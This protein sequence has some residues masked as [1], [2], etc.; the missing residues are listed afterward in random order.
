MA[1][2]ISGGTGEVSQPNSVQEVILEA[3]RLEESTLFSAK[4]HFA[5][6]ETWSKLHLWVGVPNSVAAAIAGAMA[7]SFASNMWMPII[8]GGLSIL[9]AGLAAVQTF[10]NP[11]EKSAAHFNAGNNYDALNGKVRIFWTVECWEAHPDR[12]LTE[13]LKDFAGEKES[14]NRTCPQIP[15]WAYRRAKE[16]IVK[17]EGTYSVDK[18]AAGSMPTHTPSVT[19]DYWREA[20]QRLDR[21][22][23]ELTATWMLYDDGH[24]EW[25]V[26]ASND[27]AGRR[28]D[29]FLSEARMLGRAVSGLP[30]ALRFPSVSFSDDADNWLNV[31]A[32]IVKPS[33]MKGSGRNER[34][35]YES[36]GIDDLVDASKVACARLAS[37]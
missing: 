17:G 1:D 12:V 37:S 20:E 4:G 14:L 13:K 35:E 3:K 33:R 28:V 10:L 8:G 9:A 27:S 16:G 34:G 25:S 22:D 29:R 6:A 11:N 15:S 30:P 24:V 19:S 5:A 21:I 36:G 23:G 7:L 18:P 32:A 31:V 26:Y 2:E